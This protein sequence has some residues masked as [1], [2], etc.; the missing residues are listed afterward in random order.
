MEENWP[1]Q[2]GDERHRLGSQKARVTKAKIL[3]SESLYSSRD[4]GDVVTY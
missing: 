4:G 3:C 2:G 1:R